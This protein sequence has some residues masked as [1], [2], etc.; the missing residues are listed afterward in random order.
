MNMLG[1]IARHAS[2][3][4]ENC[5]LLLSSHFLIYSPEVQVMCEPIDRKDCYCTTEVFMWPSIVYHP[6]RLVQATLGANIWKKP[7]PLSF[8]EKVNVA[9]KGPASHARSQHGN[10][11]K[12]Q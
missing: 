7:N 3:T 2:N 5:Q 4:W 6:R 8:D 12:V 11:A 1:R 10:L 9:L